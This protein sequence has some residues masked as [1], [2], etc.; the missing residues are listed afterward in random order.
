MSKRSELLAAI[1]VMLEISY[2][3]I[4]ISIW[5]STYFSQ[6]SAFYKV[7]AIFRYSSA[8]V[9]WHGWSL[10]RLRSLSFFASSLYWQGFF[11]M[12]ALVIYFIEASLKMF[13]LY[14]RKDEVVSETPESFQRMAFVGFL[15]TWK[16]L[17]AAQVA[18]YIADLQPFKSKPTPFQVM[19]PN[20][21]EIWPEN[22]KP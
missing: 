16:F 20:F 22:P 2:L 12:I 9:G 5:P 15:A 6:G 10:K 19:S 7:T 18:A 3:L 11:F 13:T 17:L 1:A 8:L 14:F 21:I 4:V